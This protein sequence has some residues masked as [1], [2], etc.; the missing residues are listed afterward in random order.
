MSVRNEV[1]A[2]VMDAVDFTVFR[3]LA[4]IKGDGIIEGHIESG[5]GVGHHVRITV[6]IV[7]EN[8]PNHREPSVDLNVVEEATI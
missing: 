6:D 8:A 5:P 1:T 4:E 7:A 2:A 3:D